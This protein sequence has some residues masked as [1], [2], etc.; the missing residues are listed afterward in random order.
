MPPSERE[1]DEAAF[2]SWYLRTHWAAMLSAGRVP[3]DSVPDLAVGVGRL[4]LAAFMA[5]LERGRAEAAGGA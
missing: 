2:E 3:K 5:G 4:C 1:G